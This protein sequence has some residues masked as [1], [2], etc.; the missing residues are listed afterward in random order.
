MG[1]RQPVIGARRYGRCQRKAR[2]R[3]HAALAQPAH[4]PGEDA[5]RREELGLDLIINTV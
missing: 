2:L 1:F 3:I 5:V 4:H